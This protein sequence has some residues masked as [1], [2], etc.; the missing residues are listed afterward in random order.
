MCVCVSSEISSALNVIVVLV[1]IANQKELHPEFLQEISL[2]L[3]LGE[4]S[5]ICLSLNICLSLYLSL[6]VF[7]ISVLMSYISIFLF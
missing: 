6:F 4:I 3:K 7:I 2:N 1:L 5:T